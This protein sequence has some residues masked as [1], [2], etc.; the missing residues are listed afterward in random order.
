MG[1]ALLD[2]GKV[3]LLSSLTFIHS[4][5]ICSEHVLCAKKSRLV[6]WGIQDELK[7]VFVFSR[8]QKY[9]KRGMS[10]KDLLI[11]KGKE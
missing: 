8:D 1:K 11:L 9:S 5:N 7:T 4:F 2:F 10:H 6:L 3:L